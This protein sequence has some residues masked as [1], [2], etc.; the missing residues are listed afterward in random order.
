MWLRSPESEEEIGRGPLRPRRLEIAKLSSGGGGGGGEEG[1][2]VWEIAPS[3]PVI[4]E[5]HDK[6]GKGMR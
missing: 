3:H 1:G 6:L 2:E 4:G 5:P